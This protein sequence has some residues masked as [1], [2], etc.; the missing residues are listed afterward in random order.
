MFARLRKSFKK[1][2]RLIKFDSLAKLQPTAEDE[3]TEDDQL[4]ARDLYKM[5]EVLSPG[6]F[7]SVNPLPLYMKDIENKN[8]GNT[9]SN[10][11]GNGYRNHNKETSP[12]KS[13]D[14]THT[15]S[16]TITNKSD[17]T[18]S[19]K[20]SKTNNTND[21]GK[22]SN[23]T[24]VTNAII[25]NASSQETFNEEDYLYL[26]ANHLESNDFPFFNENDNDQI[27]SSRSAEESPTQR[28]LT[29][30]MEEQSPKEAATLSISQAFMKSMKKSSSKKYRY[31]DDVMDTRFKTE[32]SISVNSFNQNHSPNSY[33]YN[34]TNTNGMAEHEKSSQQQLQ[35]EIKSPDFDENRIR[36]T[37]FAPSPKSNEIRKV[38]PE[39]IYQQR[40]NN[41]VRE[42]ATESE[43]LTKQEVID[44]VFSK[45]RHNHLEQ[46]FTAIYNGFDL[47]SIDRNGNT[48]LHICAQNN[49]KKIAS[50]VI[51]YGCNINAN[52][53]KNLTALD[54]CETYQFAKMADWLISK[55]A[56][57][58]NQLRLPTKKLVFPR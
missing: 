45:A 50:M 27:T 34:R 40:H 42:T 39:T 41:N 38:S 56:V 31:Q 52:N 3:I 14:T 51:Q 28:Q 26:V 9:I 49:R 48:I 33:N 25:T 23:G 5:E 13:V 18:K 58:G 43:E 8:N 24:N 57:N 12:S 1:K 19:T 7:S 54:Y 29:S 32:R 37:I 15:K 46:V 21:T 16:T 20:S 55:G 11:K 4:Y 47:T 30:S 2:E 36:R 10:N 17:E 22:N 6:E 35:Q 44:D 53:Y